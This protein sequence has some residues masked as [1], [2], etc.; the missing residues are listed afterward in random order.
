MK[1][2]DAF[3]GLGAN[4]GDAAGSLRDAAVAIEAL[5]GTNVVALSQMYRSPAW[6]VVEQPDF[7]NAVAH[8]STSLKARDLLDGL[9][10]IEHRAGRDRSAASHW[11]PRVLDL[12]ILLFGNDIIDEP[13]LRVPHPH[14]HERAFALVPLLDVAPGVVIPG[15]G[16]VA[17]LLATVDVSGVRQLDPS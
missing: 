17:A 13:G 6:G 11:G 8:V 15:R 1:L 16:S 2:T 10:D 4:L 9:L 3:I 7:V 5:P 12:D 14:L